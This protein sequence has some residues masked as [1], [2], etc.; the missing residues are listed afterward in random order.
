MKSIRRGLAVFLAVLMMMPSVPV[1]AEM[2]NSSENLSI[3]E[4]A[5]EDEDVVKD[6]ET[7]ED[8]K[9]TESDAQKVLFN[10]GT[11]EFSVVTMDAL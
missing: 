5:V 10:T 2:I 7:V 4:E 6:E 1:A 8:E 9:V 11:A 3:V